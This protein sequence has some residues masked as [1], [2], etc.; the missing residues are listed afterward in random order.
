[1]QTIKKDN[2]LQHKNNFQNIEKQKFNVVAALVSPQ[3]ELIDF[4]SNHQVHIMVNLS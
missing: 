4:G 1:M 3:R 2:F